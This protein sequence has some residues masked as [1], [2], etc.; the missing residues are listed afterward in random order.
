[1]KKVVLI[2]AG[3][4]MGW[5]TTA[6]LRNDSAYDMYYLEV[7]PEGIKRLKEIDIEVTQAQEI[8]PHAD[9]VILAIPD[10]AIRK[11]AVEIVPQIKAGAM[12][13]TLD[14][15]AP[16]AGHL[17]QRE[18]ITYF[19]AHP[20]HPSVFNWEPNE[21]AHFDYFGG[22][23]ARQ[24]I[25][26]ALI[27]GPEEDYEVGKK[28]ASSMYAPVTKAHRVTIEQ[29]GILEPALSETFAAAV[30]TVMKEAVDTVVAKGVP[31]E[32]A[33]DFFLGHVNIELALLFGQLPGG[34]FSDA[35][36]KAIEIGKPLIF[37]ENWKD[38]FEWDNVMKQIKAIT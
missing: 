19:A 11:V 3:G 2:G 23:A 8:L 24:S 25:V 26:C 27:Q 33:Y 35:A 38:I 36:Y 1:M 30:I 29:M 4:K 6:N 18:D 10:V 9:I 37:K 31:K 28:L 34:Q 15:A 7:S 14:P 16:C 21:K 12:V 22:I 17:P 5:R 13:V 32:A 20:S